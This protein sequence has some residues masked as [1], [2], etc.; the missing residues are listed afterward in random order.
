MMRRLL[1][2]YKPNTTSIQSATVLISRIVKNY[3]KHSARLSMV[4]IS[5]LQL[6]RSVLSVSNT[7]GTLSKKECQQQ[8][9]NKKLNLQPSNKKP[10]QKQKTYL[11]RMIKNYHMKKRVR[12]KNH[13]NLKVSKLPITTQQILIVQVKETTQDLRG[14]MSGKNFKVMRARR[15][16]RIGFIGQDLR[17][18]KP[19][20]KTCE[21]F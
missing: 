3:I 8:T 4:Q 16:K 14:Q 6:T 20:S 19:Q 11:K 18:E 1:K 12:K 17:K 5:Q 9:R 2:A 7:R 21:K 13:Q 10:F 15:K